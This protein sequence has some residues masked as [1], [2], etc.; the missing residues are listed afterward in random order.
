MSLT[1]GRSPAGAVQPP[2]V[3]RRLERQHREDRELAGK[4]RRVKPVRSAEEE[5]FQTVAVEQLRLEQCDLFIRGPL[6]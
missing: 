1:S 4:G 5:L 3:R 6:A 2:P